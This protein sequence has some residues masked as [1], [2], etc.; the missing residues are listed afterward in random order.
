LRFFGVFEP[1]LPVFAATPFYVDRR[2]FGGKSRRWRRRGALRTW[3]SS[4]ENPTLWEDSL[5]AGLKSRNRPPGRPLGCRWTPHSPRGTGSGAPGPRG[6]ILASP[7]WDSRQGVLRRAGTLA[8]V[9]IKI[10]NTLGASHRGAGGTRAP[11]PETPGIFQ[12][13][14][15]NDPQ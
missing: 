8:G 13:P 7:G 2:F 10:L 3:R 5:S 15:E 1:F 9:C 14:I 12:K 4:W 6:A 11:G